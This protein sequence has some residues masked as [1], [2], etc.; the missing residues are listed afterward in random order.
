MSRDRETDSDAKD[1]SAHISE[2]LSRVG[3][4]W[5][6]QTVRAMRDGPL[7]FNELRRRVGGISQKM[8]TVTLRRL[9]RDGFVLRTV[10]PTT[11]PQVEY[12]LTDL[13]DSLQ[14]PVCGLGSWTVDNA[15]AIQAARAR[16]DGNGES[17]ISASTNANGSMKALAANAGR[18]LSGS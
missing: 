15:D 9:E 12:A 13:G 2:M 7:R 4:S 5:T 3:D 10:H 6:I 18:A 17:E 1:V 16:Y 14:A 11:P 8:L